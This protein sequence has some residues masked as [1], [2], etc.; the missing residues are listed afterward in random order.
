MSSV[1]ALNFYPGAD[2][3]NSEDNNIIIDL[4]KRVDTAEHIAFE[5]IRSWPEYRTR[6]LNRRAI[7]MLIKSLDYSASNMLKEHCRTVYTGSA[8]A[9]KLF[10][11]RII[12][13]AVS[14]YQQELDII[15]DMI[16]EY[17]AYLMEGNFLDQ[18]LFYETRPISECWD[19]RKKNGR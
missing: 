15:N 14:F 13:R 11:R 7:R 2:M 12:M 3:N 19:R 9:T 8:D 17:E 10:A 6:Q 16:S 5:Y 1:K 18:F 4:I